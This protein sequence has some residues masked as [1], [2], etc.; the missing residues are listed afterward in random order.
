MNIIVDKHRYLKS[1]LLLLLLLPLTGVFAGIELHDFSS[2]EKEKTY[3]QLTY[4]LRCL[5]CQNQNLADSNADL[6]KDLREEVF[7]MVE[8]GKSRQ[9]I[10]DFMVAR[11]GDF[12]LY[13]PPLQANTT[14]L[15]I[16]PFLILVGGIVIA[17]IF[18]RR[19]RLNA[20]DPEQPE[21]RS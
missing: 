11:Y 15:W 5:V 13:R 18:I 7:E 9:D 16:G 10:I 3:K 20:D 12:V 19:H 6:A 8:S 17:I 1:A 2:P 14:F 21:D 4:E